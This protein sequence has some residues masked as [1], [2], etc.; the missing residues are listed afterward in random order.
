MSAPAPAQRLLDFVHHLRDEGFTVGIR[1]YMDIL[2]G[3]DNERLPDERYSRNVIRS[4][5]C[6]SPDEWRRFDDLFADWWFESSGNGDTPDSSQSKTRGGRRSGISG[7][8]GTTE[9]PPEQYG[10]RIELAGTGAGRQRTI[11]KADFRF[12]ND[13][14]AMFEVERLAEHLAQQLKLRLRRRTM[15]QARGTRLAL[16]QTIRRNL[17][18]GGFPAKP[19]YRIRQREPVHIVILHDVSH[20]MAWNNPLLFRFARG[21]ARAFRKSEVYAFHTRLFRVTEFYREQSLAVMKQRLEERNHLWLGGTC[22][23]ESMETFNRLYA[24]KTLTARSIL[25]VISDG[26]DTNE[27]EYLAEQLSRIK[28]RVSRVLWLNPMLG[29]EGY[30]PDQD[31]VLAAMPHIDRHFPAHSLDS[32]KSTVDYMARVCRRL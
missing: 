16:R 23:A 14:K 13:R 22:I 30:E 11:S 1:E 2:T 31:S 21:I 25:I 3:L 6:H 19:V 26:F 10:E 20:S 29:R 4:L 7:L 18:C 17:S 5:A 32:L 27:P 28:K 24:G 12:L 15:Y 8:G 9:Q